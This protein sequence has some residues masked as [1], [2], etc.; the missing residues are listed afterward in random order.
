MF[1]YFEDIAVGVGTIQFPKKRRVELSGTSMNMGIEAYTVEKDA[2][3]DSLSWK[4]AGG[5][6]YHDI[7]HAGRKQRALFDKTFDVPAYPA[8]RRLR[9]F[10]KK[11]EVRSDDVPDRWEIRRQSSIRRKLR[12]LQ[13]PRKI[14]KAS[15]ILPSMRK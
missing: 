9:Y 1:V 12:S 14:T 15:R 13:S 6:G 2:I 10:W 4:G 11:K 3:L 8:W 7:S 5:L